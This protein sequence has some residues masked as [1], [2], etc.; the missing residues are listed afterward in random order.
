MRLFVFWLRAQ[1]RAAIGILPAV[2]RN[3]DARNR[4]KRIVIN[5]LGSIAASSREF[6]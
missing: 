6:T 5:A 2:F 1:L 3:A 4:E